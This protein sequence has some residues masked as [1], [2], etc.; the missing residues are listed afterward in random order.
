M[1][2][3]QAHTGKSDADPPRK[4]SPPSEN[5]I[6][7]NTPFFLTPVGLSTFAMFGRALHRQP[8]VGCPQPQEQLLRPVGCGTCT[9]ME[10]ITVSYSRIENKKAQREVMGCGTS[11][12][13]EKLYTEAADP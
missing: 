8:G 9:H 4:G 1:G 3:G 7:S 12:L 6:C 10:L 11:T 5:T 13:S 2:R